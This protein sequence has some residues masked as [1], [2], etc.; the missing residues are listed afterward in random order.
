MKGKELNERNKKE[1]SKQK[2][3]REDEGE[4]KNNIKSNNIFLF[5]RN[6]GRP[7]RK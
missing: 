6:E 5:A 7:D 2:K 1:I 3:N 4:R